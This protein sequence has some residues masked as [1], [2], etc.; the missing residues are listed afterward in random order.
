VSRHR[1]EIG[2]RIALGARP[3]SVMWMVQRESLIL[4]AIGIAVGL[5]GTLA[6]GRFV[7][8]LLFQVAPTD[9]VALV[10]ASAVMLLVAAGAALFP[11]HRA[12]RVDPVVALRSDT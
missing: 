4:A 1:H 6:L 8:T 11:S 2:V 12:A 10:T 3:R 9:P 7:R 5:G